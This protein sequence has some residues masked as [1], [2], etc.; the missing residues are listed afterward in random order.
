M[1][2]STK[3]KSPTSSSRRARSCSGIGWRPDPAIPRADGWGPGRGNLSSWERS[4]LISSAS[5]SNRPSI[6]GQSNPTC[7]ARE[8]SF[9]LRGARAYQGKLRRERIRVSRLVWALFRHPPPDV[10]SSPQPSELPNCG[11]RLKKFQ[12]LH[13]RRRGGGGPPVSWKGDPERHR[14]KKFLAP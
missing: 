13:R 4:S 2:T 1:F 9:E 6:L 8:L 12:P 7:A 14:W 11:G 5:F 3:N 10:S